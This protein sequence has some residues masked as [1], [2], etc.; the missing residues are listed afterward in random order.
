MFNL[1]DYN[2]IL[3]DEMI[4]HAPAEPAESA[5]LL[6]F[7]WGA[8]VDKIVADLPS[9]LGQDFVIYANDTRVVKARVP[10]YGCTVTTKH[11]RK[12]IL[13]YAEIFFLEKHGEQECECLIQL[14]KRNRPGTKI[15][16]QDEIYAEITSLT[17]KG[18]I[19]KLTWISVD[20]LLNLYWKMPLPPYIPTSAETEKKYQ[21]V[22]AKH[23]WSVA[24]PTASLHLTENILKAL[25]E[26]G[27]EI[28]Y[29]TLH[30]GLWTFKPVDTEDIRA[31]AIHE[32]T[33]VI[34]TSV[35]SSLANQKRNGKRVIAIWTTMARLLETLPYIWAAWWLQMDEHTNH[36]WN[37]LVQNLSQEENDKQYID[38]IH[39]LNPTTISVKT[40]IFIYP[41]F[42]WK[43]VDGLMTNFHL[44]QSTLL[45]L[46]ASFIWFDQMKSVYAHAIQH[47]YRFYSFGD[48]SL[49]L[50]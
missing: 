18:V 30:V 35:F 11:G 40:R 19:L 8:I 27:V 50:H 47:E 26:K 41:W 38:T 31:Y 36:F 9:Y 33:I 42:I 20:E 6:V 16:I 12:V 45:M 5:K 14:L 15:F 4:A 10:L 7:Q 21:T 34:E 23:D 25:V 43:I 13:P 46:V 44:P 3:P 24:A 48:A 17:S 2:Y 32:E 22:F 29:T 49:L 37:T 39:Y 28:Q 1:S